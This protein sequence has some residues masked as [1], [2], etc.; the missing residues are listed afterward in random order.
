[1]SN[2]SFKQSNTPDFSGFIP[3]E[4]LEAIFKNKNAKFT[5]SHPFLDS[6]GEDFED[7]ALPFGAVFGY[8][9]DEEAEDFMKTLSTIMENFGY[10]LDTEKPTMHPASANR[11]SVK[12]TFNTKENL[13]KPSQKDIANRVP[14]SNDRPSTY[15][16]VIG[17]TNIEIITSDDKEAYLFTMLLPGYKKEDVEISYSEKALFVDIVATKN[18]AEKKSFVKRDYI[19]ESNS[20]KTE[21]A[22]PEADFDNISSISLEAG[23][24]T[25]LIP[26]KT[27]KDAKKKLSF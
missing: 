9:P 7:S 8:V 1:M 14:L 17:L 19:S 25:I 20:L 3:E 26:K 24:L 27:D 6:I 15:A 16:R 4:I 21:F 13:A 12:D 22:L 10:S 18:V 2:N 5:P 23:V 11:E